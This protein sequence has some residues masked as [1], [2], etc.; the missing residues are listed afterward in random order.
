M[1]S[2]EEK[3]LELFFENPT[4]EWHFEELVK[5]AKLARS[6]LDA[7]LKKFRKEGLIKRIKEKGKMPYYTAQY[8]SPAYVSAK[9]MF[10]LEKLHSSGFL[11]HLL[12]LKEAETIIIFGSI[13]RG[14]WH[15]DSDIDLFVYGN[16]DD[17]QLGKYWIKLDREI[18]FFGCKN[19]EELKKY[20]PALLKNILN[21]YT[22]K[23]SIPHL[24]VKAGA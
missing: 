3:I 8:D 1:K 19:E 2:K 10:A 21:G 18:Q 9:K 22:V 7:W 23:G 13:I 11:R 4:R 17:L 5:E 16:A 24:E 14:D 6:K 20:S 15:K 12:S